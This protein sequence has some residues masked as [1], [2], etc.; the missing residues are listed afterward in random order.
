MASALQRIGGRHGCEGGVVG[1]SDAG[2]HR[3]CRRMV[4]QL[5]VHGGRRGLAVDLDLQGVQ[6]GL[7]GLTGQAQGQTGVDRGAAGSVGRD[8]AL[9]CGEVRGQSVGGAAALV[10]MSAVFCVVVSSGVYWVRTRLSCPAEMPWSSMTGGS[11]TPSSSTR[12][13]SVDGKRLMFI[14]RVVEEVDDVPG[15]S[16]G[17]SAACGAARRR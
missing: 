4:R 2:V 10:P 3:C 5:E 14:L 15:R 16:L 9:C 17:S 12:P 8:E 1:G 7:V 11:V 6:G 13:V